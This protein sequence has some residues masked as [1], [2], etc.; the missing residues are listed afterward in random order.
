MKI[1]RISCTMGRTLNMGSFESLRVDSEFAAQID[2]TEDVEE[3]WDELVKF[4]RKHL[5]RAVSEARDAV[6]EEMENENE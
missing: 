4:T 3:C 1:R 6:E 2:E 5:K